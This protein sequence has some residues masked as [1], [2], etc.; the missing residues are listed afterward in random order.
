MQFDCISFADLGSKGLS[1]VFSTSA[2]I[3]GD[4]LSVLKAAPSGA[5]QTIITSP[6]YWSLRDYHVDGQVGAEQTVY[7]Y[8]DDLVA[9]FS[10]ARR[11][12]RDDGTLWL[13]IGDSYT[14]GGRKWRAPDKK[15]RGR[16]MD[17]RPDTPEGLKPKELIG[18]PWRL[19]LK[20]QEEGWYLR[21]D[22]IW[23]KPNCQPESVGDRPTQSHEHVFLF[24]KSEHYKYNVHAVKGPNGRRVR[25][26]WSIPTKSYRAASGHF[27]IYPIELVNP[28]LLFG[29]DKND[30]VLD[31]F[32]GSG[33]TA[34]AAARLERR[35]IGIE[36]NPTYCSMAAKRIRDDEAAHQGSLPIDETP[37]IMDEGSSM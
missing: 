16:A 33:T 21:S 10:E 4:A 30:L 27:A 12:L 18:V 29:T 9:V 1:E 8:L 36:I 28:C 34:V 24:A 31:P 5:V 17:Y 32:L 35:F 20:L 26:V 15:N 23:Q 25:D 22:I 19:A 2:I 6:P 14:S 3:K 11:V 37:I 13:N 7:E